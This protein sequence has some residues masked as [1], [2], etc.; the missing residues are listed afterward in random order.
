MWF[1]LALSCF[2]SFWLVL[3]QL[4]SL[5]ESIWLALLFCFLAYFGSC[6]VSL[7]LLVGRFRSFS[8]V[9]SQ[10]WF[11]LGSLLFNFIRFM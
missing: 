11:P 9:L 1:G 10:F 3:G 6:F 7:V 4:K 5:F 8:F 2:G